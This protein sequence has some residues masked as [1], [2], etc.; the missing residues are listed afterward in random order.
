MRLETNCIGG[1]RGRLHHVPD[2]LVSMNGMFGMER[3]TGRSTS[4]TSRPTCKRIV[5]LCPEDLVD[6]QTG[7]YDN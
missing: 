3:N 7:K 2:S 5:V 1:Y 6:S 4:C